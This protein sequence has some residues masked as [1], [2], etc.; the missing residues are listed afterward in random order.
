[1]KEFYDFLNKGE[2]RIPICDN[3]GTKIWPPTK[4]CNYCYSKKIRMSKIDTN[5]QIIENT[6][7]FMGKRHNLG[8]VEMSGIR[9]IGILNDGAIKSRASVKLSKCGVNTDNSPFFEFSST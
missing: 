2:F 5:G 4:F 7:S 6:K 3:C 9:V 8:L 1:M